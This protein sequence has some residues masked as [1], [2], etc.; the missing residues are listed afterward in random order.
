M[1]TLL[2]E[3]VYATTMQSSTSH[4]NTGITGST[5][6][7]KVL[8]DETLKRSTQKTLHLPMVMGFPLILTYSIS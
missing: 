2:L 8:T 5:L 1:H 3:Y 6:F 7:R 4:R